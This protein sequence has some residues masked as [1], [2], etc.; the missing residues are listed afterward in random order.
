MQLAPTPGELTERQLWCVYFHPRD[1]QGRLREPV[2]GEDSS[3]ETATLPLTV[4]EALQQL[5]ILHH[6]VPQS[7]Y[8]EARAKIIAKYGTSSG[9]KSN[10][11]N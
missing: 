8:D 3:P 5:D 7:N 11:R 10:G 9:N 6:A 2:V 4:E 1:K